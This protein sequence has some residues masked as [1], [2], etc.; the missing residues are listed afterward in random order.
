MTAPSERAAVVVRDALAPL[1]HPAE[2]VVDADA[3][4]Q[5]LPVAEVLGPAALAY[6]SPEG[7]QPAQPAQPAGASAV[8]RLP[9]GHGSH[10]DLR[11]LEKRAGEEDAGEAGLRAITSP[12]FVVREGGQVAAAAGYELWPGRVAQ[13]SVL[14]GPEWR[15]RG[16]ARLT[17]SAAVAHALAAGLLP[18]WRA[19]VPASRRV[20][21]AL[22]FR[23]LGA[24]LSIRLAG[25]V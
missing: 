22:G 2:A 8:E 3:V 15:G 11:E 6:V 20:A 10:T 9:G 12:A 1:P 21:A 25:D 13:V 17:G 18:Q 4:R 14:T 19:R 7:F 23:E 24:Q 16:L 5:V